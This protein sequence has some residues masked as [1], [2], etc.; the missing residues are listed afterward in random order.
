MLAAVLTGLAAAVAL[1]GAPLTGAA[2][3]SND[4]GVTA[5]G[6]GSPISKVLVVSIDGLNTNA[7]REL[8]PERAPVL[9]HLIRHGASTLNART[10]YEST[11]TLPNHTGMVTGLRVDNTHGGHG[12][13][14]NID[15]ATPATVQEAARRADVESVFSTVHGKRRSTAL[16]VSKEKLM[17]FDRSWGGSIDRA[18]VRGSNTRLVTLA[19]RDLVKERRAF[20]FV[21]LSMPD[22]VGH[23]RGYMSQA[24]L[25]AVAT[26]DANLGRLVRA[27]T[28]TRVLKRHLALVVTSDHGGRGYLHDEIDK[29]KNYR[30]PFIVWGAG[31]ANGVNLYSL[32]KDYA[33]PG[34]SRPTYA[35]KQPIR[36]GDVAN[37]AARLLGLSPVPGSEFG[38]HT[39]LNVTR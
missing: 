10:E 5:R 14:W 13:N 33:A 30:V 20:T 27:I 28:H 34:K 12:V 25:R 15:K 3:T 6:S 4:Q 38:F 2:A 35:G 16:F 19:R 18:E 32:N 1:A 11:Q 29:R 22:S 36:N 9:Y 7:I 39:R 37:L 24:Y 21:H 8:G 23:Q 26:T 31:V 17:I